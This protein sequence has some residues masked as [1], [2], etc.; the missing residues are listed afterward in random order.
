MHA[1]RLSDAMCVVRACIRAW[2]DM[3]V[4]FYG[5]FAHNFQARSQTMFGLCIYVLKLCLAYAY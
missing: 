3:G 4:S 5:T 2:F 1:L